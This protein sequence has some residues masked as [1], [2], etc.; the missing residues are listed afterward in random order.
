ML[1]A[2]FS[3][4]MMILLL[5]ACASVLIVHYNGCM[6]AACEANRSQGGRWYSEQAE[7]SRPVSCMQPARHSARRFSRQGH[8]SGLPFPAPGILPARGLNPCLCLS[9]IPR[10]T[11]HHGCHL[12]SGRCTVLFKYGKFK[13]IF[14]FFFCLCVFDCPYVLFAWK[15]L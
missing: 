3:A 6:Q 1:F 11:R 10:Q 12:G 14:F 13:N 2:L 7:S 5:S 9:C 8:C 4:F 15:I